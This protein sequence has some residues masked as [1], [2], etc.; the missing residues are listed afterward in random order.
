MNA[1]A[2]WVFILLS[3]AVGTCLFCS[4]GTLVARGAYE[5]LHYVAPCGT[6]AAT[7]VALA[8]IVQEGFG[9]A[10]I[11]SLLVLALL[12]FS[13]PVLTQAT[14]R[15]VRRRSSRRNESESGEE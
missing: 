15:A 6:V 4:L 9:P 13:G 7:A 12:T 10:C 11:K 14:A 3:L 8:V 2:P 1:G 5:K